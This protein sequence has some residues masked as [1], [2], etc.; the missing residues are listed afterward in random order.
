MDTDEN[1]VE[2]EPVEATGE[3]NSL[4]DKIKD[5]VAGELTGEN[6]KTVSEENTVTVGQTIKL[7]GTS[8][9]SRY[10]KYSQEWKSKDT[11]IATVNND[12][13]VTGVSAGKVTIS[14]KYCTA[15][16]GGG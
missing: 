8:N 11:N 13:T 9:S 5:W 2:A 1:V 4:L 16:H 14:H 7:N 15:S 3:N 10:C 6:V 12:G